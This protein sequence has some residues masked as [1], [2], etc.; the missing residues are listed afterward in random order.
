MAE[1]FITTR[2]EESVTVPNY[3]PGFMSSGRPS[4]TIHAAKSGSAMEGG[5]ESSTGHV[6]LELNTPRYKGS[7]GFSPGSDLG[8]SADNIS[9][10]DHLI[11]KDTSS[12][13]VESHDPRFVNMLDNLVLQVEGY[14]N[15]TTQPEN[16]DLLFNNCITFVTKMFAKAGKEIKLAKT[17][18]EVAKDIKVVAEQ[19][20]TPLLID[21]EGH[22]ITTLPLEQ[23]IEFDY[24]GDADPILTG[25]AGKSSGFL[26]LDRNND[27]VINDASEL[28]GDRTPLPAGGVAE[29]GAVALAALDSNLDGLIDMND[30]VWGD[31]KIWQDINSNGASEAAELH[32]VIDI[33]LKSIDL[34]FVKNPITDVNGNIHAL[35]SFV[36]WQDGQVSDIVDVLFKT[37]D[38]KISNDFFNPTAGYFP[39]E[40]IGSKDMI[41][42]VIA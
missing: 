35:H 28:F 25:W 9:F 27:G 32:S 40:P 19:F 36:M 8:T 26:V 14:K 4:F 16:Y 38:H 12:H 20:K 31:L 2:A 42:E 34:S 21:L 41:E 7:I 39:A 29:D 15:G 23:G 3:N 33:G 37:A 6:F 18:N 22:G 10:N 17:P 13:R 30:P 1:H 5:N 24:D 11:Y